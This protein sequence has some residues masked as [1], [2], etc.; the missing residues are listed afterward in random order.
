VADSVQV[1]AITNIDGFRNA[2]TPLLLQLTD[3]LNQLG[4]APQPALGS[5]PDATD[6]AKAHEVLLGHFVGEVRQLVD[7]L[8]D[9]QGSVGTT[10][11]AVDAFAQ[12]VAL[13]TTSGSGQGQGSA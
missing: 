1:D 3:A 2:L 4:G 13:V 7:D 12:Y 8:K 10:V 11:S 9:F 5:F 6:T